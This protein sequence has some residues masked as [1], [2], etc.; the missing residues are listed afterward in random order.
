MV[1]VL[2]P[3]KLAFTIRNRFGGISIIP[4]SERG[5]VDYVR[6]VAK[7]G[8]NVNHVNTSAGPRFWRR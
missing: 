2:L 3:A 7:I 5:H 4:A 6:R 1:E 8:M